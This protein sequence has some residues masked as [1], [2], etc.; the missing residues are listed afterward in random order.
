MP[1]LP[2]GL[3]VLRFGELESTNKYARKLAETGQLRG[4]AAVIIAERQ[5]D[6][7]GRFRRQWSSPVGGLWCTLA[8]PLPEG[9][10][11][12]RVLD[13]LGLRVG[14]G[15][16]YAIQSLLRKTKRPCEVRLKWPNDVMVNSRKVAGVLCELVFE[17]D[18]LAAHKY[19]LVGVGVNANIASAQLPFELR[20]KATGLL[21]HLPKPIPL[22]DLLAVILH[23]LYE[24]VPIEGLPA[25][26]LQLVRA[27]LFGVGL[28]AAVSLPQGQKVHGV[29]LGIDHRGLAQLRT[30]DGVFTAPSGT[31][32]M[33]EEPPGAGK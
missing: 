33:T 20:E 26:M 7:V 2:P 14:L 11:G 8:W 22:D 18:S 13:G 25:E 3:P 10:A 32:L 9:P 16:T 27:M 23:Q 31:V 28:P 6:G 17:R 21:D 5:T 30:D 29:L 1:K 24:L 15:C 12:E 4:R 19:V